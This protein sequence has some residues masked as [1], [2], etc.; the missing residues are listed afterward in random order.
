LSEDQLVKLLEIAT[1]DQLFLF[2]GQLFKQVDGV[3]MGSPLGPLVANAM[4]CLLEEKLENEGKLPEN[5]NLFVDDTLSAVVNM[6]EAHS[7]HQALNNAHPS[8]SFTMEVQNENGQLPFLGTMLTKEGNRLSTSV[9]RK[10]T[11]TGL[12]LHYQSQVDNRYKIGLIKTMLHRAKMLSSSLQLFKEEC[13]RLLLLFVRLKYPEALVRSI[14]SKVV[15]EFVVQD[16]GSQDNAPHQT[17]V[18]DRDAMLIHC[19]YN[20]TM[21]IHCQC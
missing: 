10:C 7:F 3:A 4:M 18:D 5:Y 2:D 8:L 14:I 20:V 16:S 17:K 13:D 6:G 11:D 19:L 12:L 21:L 9:Y 15:N 1:K